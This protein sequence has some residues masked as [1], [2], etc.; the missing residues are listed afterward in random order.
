M[1][2]SWR[3]AHGKRHVQAADVITFC[4]ER[5]RKL[6]LAD[7]VRLRLRHSTAGARSSCIVG[8]QRLLSDCTAVLSIPPHDGIE[9]AAD[10]LRRWG[11]SEEAVST[12]RT[13][14]EGQVGTVGA[15]YLEEQLK[16]QAE[17]RDGS[18]EKERPGTPSRQRGVF[19]RSEP[20]R[21][22]PARPPAR[23]P[24]KSSAARPPDDARLAATHLDL[25][26][27]LAVLHRHWTDS[28]LR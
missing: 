7:V 24:A 1:I 14:L 16:A 3:S 21:R 9:V 10:V 2:G 13:Q 26:V 15:Q 8:A 18:P 6:E 5:V 11:C 23:S 12:L 17:A 25:D 28:M 4:L 19:R 27:M 22:S 20:A